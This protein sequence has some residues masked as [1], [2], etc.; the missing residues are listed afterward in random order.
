M[1]VR[2]RPDYAGTR[3]LM[4]SPE[5]QAVMRLVAGEAMAAAVALAP[6]R[7]GEYKSSFHV[8]AHADGGIHRDRAEALAV[9][10]SPHSVLVEGWDGF[11]VLRDAAAELG[12][13]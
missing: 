2:Y 12:A 8:E 7:T 1:T 13:L 4:N 11:H 5:M 3:E 6:V 10:D 9:N